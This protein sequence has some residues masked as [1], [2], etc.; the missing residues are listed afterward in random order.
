[1]AYTK[2]FNNAF[3]K[4]YSNYGRDLKSFLSDYLYDT[5]KPKRVD[6]TKVGKIWK[7]NKS[8]K[9]I[10]LE[11]GDAELGTFSSTYDMKRQYC[12]TDYKSS[13]RP[14]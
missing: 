12:K 14:N 6:A 10:L 1:M 9:E 4:L 7:D 13:D 5:G 11:V 3:D 8:N 2:I